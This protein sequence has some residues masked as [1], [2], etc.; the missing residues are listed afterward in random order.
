[1]HFKCKGKNFP[2]TCHA[3]QKGSSDLS[4]SY[5]K[6]RLLVGVGG[7]RHAPHVKWTHKIRNEP[8]SQI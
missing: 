3:T 7:H 5:F 6:P 8:V 4:L 2:R 1:M